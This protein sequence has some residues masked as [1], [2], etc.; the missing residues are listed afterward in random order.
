MGGGQRHGRRAWGHLPAP[1][2]RGNFRVF[3]PVAQGRRYDPDGSYVRRW[4]PEL[5]HLAGGDVHEPW[6]V[7]GG[8]DDGYPERIVDHAA[9]REEALA[10][11]AEVR[12]SR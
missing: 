12:G 9:E 5:R 3:N 4:V 1:W 7:P 6:A 11:Y 2:G 8:Y 10:R